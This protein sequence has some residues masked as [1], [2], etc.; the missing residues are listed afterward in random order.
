MNS[1][2]VKHAKYD[3]M[4]YNYVIASSPPFMKRFPERTPT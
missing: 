1:S 2:Q 3:Q 4:F